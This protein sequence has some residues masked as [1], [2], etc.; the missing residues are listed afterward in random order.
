MRLSERIDHSELVVGTS[1][2]AMKEQEPRTALWGSLVILKMSGFTPYFGQIQFWPNPILAN[3]ILANPILANPF[4]DLVCVMAQRVGPKPRKIGP[5]RV[6]P[7]RVGPR[8]VGPRRCCPEGW[9]GPTFRAFF[10]SPTTSFALF[11]LSL[12]VFSRFFGGVWKRRGRQMCTFGVL[13]LLCEAPAA[14]KPPASQRPLLSPVPL[15]N[16]FHSAV[17]FPQIAGGAAV[18]HSHE[19]QSL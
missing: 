1:G 19:R 7:R 11:S 12:W 14:P 3:P 9:G 6:G 5:R 10:S 15:F 18:E 8:R 17:A 4:L 13:G 2:R 16:R